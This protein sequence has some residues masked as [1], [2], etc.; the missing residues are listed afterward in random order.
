[1]DVKQFEE[2]ERVVRM[3]NDDEHFSS[4]QKALLYMTLQRKYNLSADEVNY[5]R[6]LTESNRKYSIYSGLFSKKQIQKSEEFRNRREKNDP[7]RK[8]LVEARLRAK[9]AGRQLMK[10]GKASFK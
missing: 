8:E 7:H 10:D 2:I 6:Q 1:M 5:F 3:L 4:V 9:A